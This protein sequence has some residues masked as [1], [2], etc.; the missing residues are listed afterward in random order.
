MK[1]KKPELRE[2]T[3]EE[4]RRVREIAALL[5][6]RR[7]ASELKVPP[8]PLRG[9][10]PKIQR[11]Q[12]REQQIVSGQTSNP[13]RA[14]YVPESKWNVTPVIDPE[15]HELTREVGPNDRYNSRINYRTG[16]KTATATG[17]GNKTNYRGRRAYGGG[18]NRP[19]NKTLEQ[20]LE[21]YR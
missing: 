15:K 11:H 13:T 2:L 1:T 14:M 3:P 5:Y 21:E 19:N 20:L 17:E 6:F 4:K 18:N 16:K 7:A 8:F 10:R 12:S 9:Y